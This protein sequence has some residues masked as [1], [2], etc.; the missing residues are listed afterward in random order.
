MGE[1]QARRHELPEAGRIVV[2][3]RS[4]GRSA[5]ITDALRAHGYDAVNLTG[6]MCAWA[7]AGLPVVTEAAGTLHPGDAWRQA[8]EQGM[9]VHRADPLN[10]ETPIPALIGGLV[11]PNAHFYVRNHFHAPTIDASTWSL[12]VTGLVERPLGEAPSDRGGGVRH[13]HAV[14]SRVTPSPPSRRQAARKPVAAT[15]F[16]T[17]SETQRPSPDWERALTCGN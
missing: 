1:V 11:M 14:S 6:G 13:V 2:V 12:E 8:L 17:A 10:C 15:R 7:A 9:V 4:G 3:C 16:T 5:A